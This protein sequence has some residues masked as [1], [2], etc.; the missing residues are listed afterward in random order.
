MGFKDLSREGVQ[1]LWRGWKTLIR[2]FVDEFN[3]DVY[4][5]R[6]VVRE[7]N[8]DERSYLLLETKRECLYV[9]PLS[10]N[11]L[12]FC[13]YRHRIPPERLRSR[14]PTER[15]DKE[16]LI[17]GFGLG[18]EG[19]EAHDRGVKRALQTYIGR[20]LRIIYRNHSLNPLL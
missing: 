14:S 12:A 13:V 16:N 18:V 15:P 8:Y 5:G 4:Q 17:G 3:E 6:G 11:A 1:E 20:Y 19:V 2:E 7:N 9:F 10:G